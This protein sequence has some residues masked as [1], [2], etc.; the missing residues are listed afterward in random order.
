MKTR[1]ILT[2]FGGLLALILLADCG[3]GKYVPTANEELYG[4]WT[5]EQGKAEFRKIEYA[6]NRLALYYQ[7]STQ[8]P[9]AVDSLVIAGKWK[10]SEG[11]IY[12]KGTSINTGEGTQG[13]H[14]GE[15]LIWLVKLSNSGTVLERMFV[16]PTNDE[17]IKNPVYPTK[18]DPQ[19]MFYGIYNRSKE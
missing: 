18:M 19:N 4:T 17:Q 15:F 7:P 1:T 2:V 12:Y 5:A 9:S 16:M 10:D 6:A 11:N 8:Q 14:K 3:P 13:S